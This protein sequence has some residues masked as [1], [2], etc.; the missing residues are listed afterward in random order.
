MELACSLHALGN[1]GLSLALFP[2]VCEVPVGCSLKVPWSKIPAV[3]CALFVLHPGH[4]AQVR[5]QRLS[6]SACRYDLTDWMSLKAQLSLSPEEGG[7]QNMFDIDLKVSLHCLVKKHTRCGQGQP[8]YFACSCS[9]Q[10]CQSLLQ[11]S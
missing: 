9:S 7:S 6:P 11:D 5:L 3:P 2:T 8:E 4:Q 10:L 1:L